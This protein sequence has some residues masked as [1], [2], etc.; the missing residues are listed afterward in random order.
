MYIFTSKTW[1][2]NSPEKVRR[3]NLN[4]F[5]VH[6][7]MYYFTKRAGSSLNHDSNLQDWS[8]VVSVCN[9]LLMQ[10]AM[11]KGGS[12]LLVQDRGGSSRLTCCSTPVI[13]HS[14]CSLWFGSDPL[15]EYYRALQ[16]HR[17]LIWFN[18]IHLG[19][20][21]EQKHNISWHDADLR[22]GWR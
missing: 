21:F 12:V 11:F 1:E 8:R 6:S 10:S 4:D 16:V 20:P 14:L 22:V 3:E 17:E 9:K 13:L 19:L 7:K 5:R 2:N 18:T 15:L